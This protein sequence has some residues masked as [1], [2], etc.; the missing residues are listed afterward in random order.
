MTD[1]REPEPGS[2]WWRPD[3][4]RLDQRLRA[5]VEVQL[6][7]AQ[8]VAGARLVGVL[9]ELVR[10]RAAGPPPRPV[11]DGPRSP[12]MT[13]LA[14]RF[15]LDRFATDLAAL[16]LAV[17]VDPRYRH[18][19]SAL[20][21][22]SR[23]GHPS[24]G[25]A[26]EL[27]HERSL[28]ER[29]HAALDR[30][31]PL[32][33]AAL[34]E[35][36]GTGPLPTQAVRLHPDLDP[37]WWHRAVAVTPAAAR[38][39]LGP[40]IAAAGAWAAAVTDP[41]VIVQGLAGTG[42]DAVARAIAAAAG[43]GWIEFESGADRRRAS[44]RDARWTEAWSMV[45]V[46]EAGLPDEALDDLATIGGGAVVVTSPRA[47][48]GRLAARR[49]W[50]VEVPDLDVAT[51]AAVWRDVLAGD[52]RAR[53]VDYA[54]LAARVAAGPAQMVA[55]AE[56]A[57]APGPGT[58]PAPYSTAALE[59]AARTLPPVR[60]AG[61]AERVACPYRAADLVVGPTTTSELDLVRAWFRTG[62]RLRTAMAPGMVA[63]GLTCLFHG[64]P[65]TG[66]TMAAQILAAEAG[67]DLYHVDLAQVVSK[68]IGETEKNLAALFDLLESRRALLFFDEADALFGRRTE[69]RDAHDRYANIETSYLLQRIEQYAGV[70]VLATN[71]PAN[72]DNAFLRRLQVMAE[73]ALPALRERA[74]L[75]Q[76]ML[77]PAAATA[78]DVA[79]L[80][81]CFAISGAD[82]KNAVVT[83]A[84]VA[85]DAAQPISLAHLVPAACRELRKQG[86]LI[87]PDDFG[88]LGRYLPTG[89]TDHGVA[90]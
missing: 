17:T 43:R 25:F 77:P 3:L 87:V 85:A 38:A 40:A 73:F 42:R 64:P 62:A 63:A 53:E 88:P 22:D 44:L 9:D 76:R 30:A 48:L 35:L 4:A 49:P 71:L 69:T 28:D 27:L 84:V 29:W 14:A 36:A 21:P 1:A 47:N 19:I 82:I 26:V 60:L 12:T 31:A 5:F 58:T 7:R 46:P 66:K 34:I 8:V 90:R 79:Q 33:A 80:A 45:H 86:R 32:R 41:V 6:S 55:A 75:W 2:T 23:D 78:N 13:R 56:L 83:A 74:I 61:V 65:G 67:V 15:G 18:L 39:D 52:P 57:G 20:D 11:D 16:A 10:D 24:V 81:R 70:V 89:P 51:R 50:I 37:R 68:Y 72:I 59:R 54:L